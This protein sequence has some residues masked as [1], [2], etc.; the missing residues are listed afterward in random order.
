MKV[1]IL[2]NH[3]RDSALEEINLFKSEKENEKSDQDFMEKFVEGRP[4]KIYNPL[5]SRKSYIDPRI[6]VAWC[7]KHSKYLTRSELKSKE[8]QDL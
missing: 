2:L 3:M 4:D 7:K 5:T 6:S 1:A 8:N